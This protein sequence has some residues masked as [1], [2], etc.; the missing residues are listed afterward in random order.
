MLLSRPL[1]RR[2]VQ[3]PLGAL[4][5]SVFLSPLAVAQ[6]SIAIVAGSGPPGYS[7]DGGPATSAQL[8]SP[9][10]VAVDASGN[11]FIADTGNNR[12]RRVDAATGIITTVAGNGVG[13]Y[14]GD[15][16]PA[17]SASLNQP[18]GVAVDSSGNLFIA[19]T[20]NHRI[21]RVDAVTGTITT[22]AGNGTQGFS[23]DGGAATSAELNFP[24]GVAVDGS[25]N[26]FIAD[27]GNNRIRRVDAATSVISTV[28]GD[29][30][31]GLSGDGGPAISASLNSPYGVGVDGSGN[32][33]I[34][35]T[36]NNLIRMVDASSGEITTVAGGGNNVEFGPATDANLAGPQGLGVDAT[37]NFLIADTENNRVSRV[38]ASSGTIVAIA[39]DICFL[40]GHALLTCPYSPPPS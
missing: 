30:T 34:A 21:R 40:A 27:T 18:N 26:L 3:L 36:Q 13:G 15:G 19:D 7:G 23:G 11:F 32:L 16:G 17:T 37:G 1:F 35:D 29:G 2:H 4:L 39:G 14:S 10:G 6:G 28:A 25:G 38:D 9:Q 20:G 24:Y 5:A 31:T 12:I 22:V 33:F 8:N